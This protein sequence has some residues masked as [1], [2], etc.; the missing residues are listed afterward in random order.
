MQSNCMMGFFPEI[1]RAWLTIDSDLFVWTCN[2]ATDLAYFNRL[3]ETILSVTLARHKP[4]IF[5]SHV[6]YLLCLATPVEVI[7]LGVSFS[8]D[9]FYRSEMHLIPEPLFTLTSD[10]TFF[11]CM[12]STPSGRI[13][14]GSKDGCLYEF[15]YQA[16]DGWFTRKCRKINHSSL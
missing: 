13:F 7:L 16:S 8:G 15:F 10:N 11:V 2:N 14:M 1:G 9:D 12:A 6:H 4:G 3:N 5:R